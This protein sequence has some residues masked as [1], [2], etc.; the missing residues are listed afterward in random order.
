M[1]DTILSWKAKE[2]VHYEK[3]I[4]WYITLTIL[5]I[6][7]ISYEVILKDYFAALTIFVVYLSLY[8]YARI[9][10]R[11]IEVSI[12][13]KAI[14]V[15]ETVIPYLSIKR[16]WIVHNEETKTLHLE[17]TAYLNRYMTLQLENEDPFV[18]AEVL[19]NFVTESEP[20]VEH[21]SR[22]IA[23]KLRF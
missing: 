1:E 16:F 8:M 9:H 5:G 3:G 21:M 2:F 19:R 10:P 20:N 6:L 15:D 18:V 11:E 13:E 7:L 22:R 23:R 4:G 14:V 17:T 12:T